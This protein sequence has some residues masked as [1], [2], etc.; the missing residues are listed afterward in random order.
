MLMSG[1]RNGIEGRRRNGNAV[2][3]GNPLAA[4]DLLQMLLPFTLSVVLE[5]LLT[6]DSFPVSSLTLGSLSL[7]GLVVS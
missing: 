6:V 2:A 5:Y 4:L 3:L 7:P 1:K